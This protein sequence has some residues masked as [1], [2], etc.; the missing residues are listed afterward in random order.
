MP[1]QCNTTTKSDITRAGGQFKVFLIS[2][3]ADEYQPPRS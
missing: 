3:R 1:T 2:F